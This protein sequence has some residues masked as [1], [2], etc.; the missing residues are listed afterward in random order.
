[1]FSREITVF[2]PASSFVSIFSVANLVRALKVWY[3]LFQVGGNLDSFSKIIE[4]HNNNNKKRK[5]IMT[6]YNFVYRM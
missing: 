4:D 1:M 3:Y 2:P 5:I 6:S